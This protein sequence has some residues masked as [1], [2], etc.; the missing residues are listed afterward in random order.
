M[1]LGKPV[2]LFL[3]PCY[4]EGKE[5]T[6]FLAGAGIVSYMVSMFN[7]LDSRKESTATVHLQHVAGSDMCAQRIDSISESTTVILITHN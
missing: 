1:A 4:S 2:E 6:L 3:L 7:S 5:N